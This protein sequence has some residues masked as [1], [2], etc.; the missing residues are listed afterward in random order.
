MTYLELKFVVL[1]HMSP[2]FRRGHNLASLGCGHFWPCQGVQKSQAPKSYSQR[3]GFPLKTHQVGERN[4]W[5]MSSRCRNAPSVRFGSVR[6]GSQLRFT[7][8]ASFSMDGCGK[9]DRLCF[10]FFH[11]SLRISENLQVA[12]G[13]RGGGDPVDP[14]WR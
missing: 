4:L 10:D 11:D 9:G 1:F 12:A 14:G 3:T 8:A 7:P 6:K 13:P 5:M 2:M